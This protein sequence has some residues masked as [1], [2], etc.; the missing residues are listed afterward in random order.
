MDDHTTEVLPPP[1]QQARRF[2]GLGTHIGE[3]LALGF[4]AHRCSA[5]DA[6][7]LK[8]IRDSG[9]FKLLGYKWA[10]FCKEELHITCRHADQMIH[11]LEV[12][13]PNFFR[14]GDLIQVSPQTYRLIAGSIS[15]EG[16]EIDGEKVP[17]N[18][19]NRD[20]IAAAVQ[21]R[22][23]QAQADVAPPDISAAER[24]L[25]EFMDHLFELAKQPSQGMALMA[26][27]E[28]GNEQLAGLH[29][30]LRKNTFQIELKP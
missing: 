7:I 10:Q 15:E 11:N 1:A 22:R 24:K 16:L 5:A 4:V 17:L 28:D 3:H 12:F 23:K 6:E 14:L 30:L 19:E 13:G 21:A 26:L 2:V 25:K 18:R 8:R 29:D 27:I 20:K 9:E